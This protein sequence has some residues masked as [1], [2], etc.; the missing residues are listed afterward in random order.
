[1]RFGELAVG[2]E[3]N[4]QFVALNP[5]DLAVLD[6]PVRF[7]VDGNMGCVRGLDRCSF[8]GNIGNEAAC[9]GAQM[10]NE[11]NRRTLSRCDFRRSSTFTSISRATR[12]CAAPRARSH[13]RFP[14]L[15]HSQK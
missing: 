7:E 3:L 5:N 10:R 8:G 11:P 15:E 2:F 12:Q 1:M 9:A 6:Y 4:A 14:F 13:C